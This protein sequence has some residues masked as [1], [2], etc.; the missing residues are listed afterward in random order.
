MVNWCMGGRD[1][2]CG[3]QGSGSEAER[4]AE[5]FGR[6]AQASVD[7]QARVGLVVA[8]GLTRKCPQGRGWWGMGARVPQLPG[9]LGRGLPALSGWRGGGPRLTQ[10]CL[11]AACESLILPGND[12]GP[13]PCA[14]DVHRLRPPAPRWLRPPLPN[15][16]TTPEAPSLEQR[17]LQERWLWLAGCLRKGHNGPSPSPSPV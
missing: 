9:S 12:G 5:G 17:V 2:R 16:P 7:Q 1:R 4:W 15:V 6:P 14:S 10:Q 13:C 11:G 8:A 3:W